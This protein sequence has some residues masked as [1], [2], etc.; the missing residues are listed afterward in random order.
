MKQ[1]RFLQ[2]LF[3]IV[4]GGL[5]GIAAVIPG[6]SGG[7]IACIIGIY[8]DLI[9]AISGIRKHFRQ[10]VLTLLP[11]VIGILVFALLLIH[12]ITWGVNQYPLITIS[13]FA[14]LLL[15]GLPSFYK[16]IQGKASVKNCTAAVLGGI[17]VLAIVIPS[18]FS[19]DSYISLSPPQAWMYFVLFLMGIIASAALVVP[20]ISGSMVLLILGFYT[21]IMDT[22]KAFFASIGL[23]LGDFSE[24]FDSSVVGSSYIVPSL[25]LLLCFGIGILIGFFLISK[26]MKYLLSRFKDTT[27]FA[28][29]GFI[30]ASLVGIYANAGYYESISAG[31][32]AL[33]VGFLIVGFLVS[34]FMGRVAEKKSARAEIQTEKEE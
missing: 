34:F 4:K 25:F 23:Q 11:Y 30:L 7:T 21:P 22:L 20:G 19:G 31:Q 33:A 13:L 2:F 17:V 16:N 27:Y 10:S 5:V 15:G 29:F 28:I 12:P 9:E 14:G 1:S 8:D 3:N 24:A 6:F 26:L 18:L 32:V